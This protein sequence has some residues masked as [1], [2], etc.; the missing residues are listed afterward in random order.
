M[1]KIK[2]IINIMILLIAGCR[3]EPPAPPMEE[4]AR[5][6][7]ADIKSETISIPVHSSGILTSSEEMKLSFK[8]G[9]IVANVSVRE[10]DNVK[11]DNILAEL[12]LSEIKAN[13]NIAASGYEKALRDWTRVKNLYA[14]TV[15]T[16]EQYQ[17]AS[18][19][20]EVTKSSLEIARFNLRHSTIKA[21]GDGIIL[22]QLVK[23]NELVSAGYPVFLFG[24]SGESWKVRSGL[25]DRDI[26]KVNQGDSAVITIDAYPG[27][28]FSGEI[29]QISGISDPMTG[30]YEIEISLNG[31]GYRLAAGFIA[32]VDV[33]PAK[34]TTVTRIPVGAIVEAD[35]ETGY[36]YIVDA[37][38]RVVKTRISIVSITG[39]YAAI[40]GLLPD[41][42]EIVSEG[43]AYLRDG[44]K[45]EVVR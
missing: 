15:A 9:G 16:L 19:A 31:T 29:E 17:N 8:A 25:S 18:T 37:S 6:K 13:V 36:I 38:G 1:K 4:V 26:V 23:E 40:S 44:M 41:L 7:T 3:N 34:K 43:A 22:K 33:F 21:P 32:G 42:T 30:T 39:E 14:D 45:V 10:G 35:G 2:L 28:R 27:I 12:N 11:K 5:V 20:L 24:V